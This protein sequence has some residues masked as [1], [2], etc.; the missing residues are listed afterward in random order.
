MLQFKF[1]PNANKKQVAEHA[2]TSGFLAARKL[3]AVMARIAQLE[4]KDA[5]VEVLKVGSE[6]VKNPL[7]VVPSEL[8]DVILDTSS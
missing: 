6:E 1:D 8:S 3:C 7:S 5:Q 2:F 4:S